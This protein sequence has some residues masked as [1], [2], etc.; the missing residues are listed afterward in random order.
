MGKLFVFLYLLFY[1]AFATSLLPPSSSSSRAATYLDV[2]R[3]PAHAVLG[4]LDDGGHVG[5]VLRDGGHQDGLGHRPVGPHPVVDVARVMGGLLLQEA[6]GLHRGGGRGLP[7]AQES[8]GRVAPRRRVCG[9]AATASHTS[10]SG[11]G[12]RTWPGPGPEGRVTVISRASCRGPSHAPEPSLRRAAPP[13]ALSPGPWGAG[14]R[15]RRES[16][17]LLGPPVAAGRA[18]GGAGSR[19]ARR[20]SLG[21][22]QRIVGARLAKCLTGEFC[23]SCFPFSHVMLLPGIS[24]FHAKEGDSTLN[25]SR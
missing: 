4:L 24:H 25:I 21:S 3:D 9:R 15:R 16:H 2:L 7:S 8:C 10:L 5:V 22:T 13:P 19:A 1:S 18:P 6:G 11:P 17:A 20:L 23:F 14:R 12:Q